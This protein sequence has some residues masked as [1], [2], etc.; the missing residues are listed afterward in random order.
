MQKN[1]TKSFTPD[2]LINTEELSWG[3]MRFELQIWL[4][5]L[6]IYSAYVKP[7]C[8]FH[9]TCLLFKL[10]LPST[11]KIFAITPKRHSFTLSL[12]RRFDTRFSFKLSLLTLNLQFNCRQRRSKQKARLMIEAL[13]EDADG[14]LHLCLFSVIMSSLSFASLFRVYLLH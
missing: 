4:Y 11:N 6:K 10:T 1:C 14:N 8:H 5:Y 12:I 13:C 3:N 9:I 7:L 2:F